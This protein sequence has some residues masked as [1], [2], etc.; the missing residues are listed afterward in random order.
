MLRIGRRPDLVV[1]PDI[2][3]RLSRF[4]IT[5]THLPFAINNFILTGLTSPLQSPSAV[6]ATTSVDVVGEENSSDGE[7][8]PFMRR[9][10]QQ[11]NELPKSRY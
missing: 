2:C 3:T 6:S 11:A 1:L 5:A 10:D 8:K 9:N 4:K 7:F